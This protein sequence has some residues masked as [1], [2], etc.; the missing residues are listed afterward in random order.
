MGITLDGLIGRALETQEQIRENLASYLGEPAVFQLKAP[1]DHDPGWDAGQFPRMDYTLDLQ[2]N[3]ERKTSGLL[4]VNLWY[5]DG[6][7]CQAQILE[8]AARDAL[9]GVF[10]RP[11][12]N[13]LYSLAW[14][15][16]DAF[17]ARDAQ[18]SAKLICGLSL[19]FDVYAFP[20]QDKDGPAGCLNSWTQDKL[21]DLKI[22]TVD[23]L[24]DSIWK[25]A[26]EEAAIYWRVSE[27]AP[28][29]SMTRYGTWS[30]TWMQS[31]LQGHVFTQSRRTLY[32]LIRRLSEQLVPYAQIPMPD[33]SPFLIRRLQANSSWDALRQG[34]I[35]LTGS[36][37]I[38]RTPPRNVIQSISVKEKT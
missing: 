34:Q 1:Q 32:A 3:P 15:R 6:C 4:A 8:P 18:E 23:H 35:A 28:D 33:G 12:G 16:T 30:V 37:G 10:L 22:I 9:D 26:G 20:Y 25:P 38:L 36:Y 31:I 27:L 5:D 7:P 24:P 19:Q 13:C 2:A 29:A 14:I 17:E 21:A 11:D